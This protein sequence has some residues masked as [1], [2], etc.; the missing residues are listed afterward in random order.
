MRATTLPVLAWLMVVYAQGRASKLRWHLLAPSLIALSSLTSRW[1][2]PP[3][4]LMLTALYLSYGLALWRASAR[5]SN[6]PEN[7]PLSDW[8]QARLA[9]RVAGSMLLFSAFIDGTLSLDFMAWDGAHALTILTVAHAT[10]IPLLALA[11]VWLSLHT[12]VVGQASTVAENQPVESA[13][14]DTTMDDAAAKAIMTQVEQTLV[15]QRLHLEHQLTL[16]RLARKSGIPSRMISTAVN[17]VYQQNISQWV[18]RFRIEHAKQL[19]TATQLPITEIFLESGFQTKSN[20]HR[21][22][23]RLVGCTPSAF[24]ERMLEANSLES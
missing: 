21:E 1:W 3:L 15:E 11:V 17:R 8:Q 2:S 24:R 5:Q 12:E 10:F 23:S 7:V 19:L 6:P 22:F 4:D 20:F 14:S 9:I 16:A 18:N 13:K